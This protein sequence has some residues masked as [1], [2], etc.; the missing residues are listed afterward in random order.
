[1]S[2]WINNKSFHLSFS[3]SIDHTIYKLH[4]LDA[5]VWNIEDHIKQVAF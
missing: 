5:I 1:V 3:K 4:L 2:W